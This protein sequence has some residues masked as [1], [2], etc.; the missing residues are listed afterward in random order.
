MSKRSLKWF[1]NSLGALALVLWFSSFYVFY[2]YHDG[3]HPNS[4]DSSSGA[5]YQSNNHGDIV[6]ITEHERN[7]HR[8]LQAIAAMIFIIGAII[9]R[10]YNVFE[11][12]NRK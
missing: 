6:Y 10:K 7:V 2:S 8:G 3:R 9:D 5:I 12:P 4:P 1:C 11:Y